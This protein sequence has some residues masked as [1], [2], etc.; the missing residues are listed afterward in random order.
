MAS[1]FAHSALLLCLLAGGCVSPVDIPTDRE[2]TPPPGSV[3]LV[4]LD[5][6]EL[7]SETCDERG[8]TLLWKRYMLQ[9]EDAILDTGQGEE[10]L[11]LLL[12]V[13]SA[14]PR[15]PR[16][17]WLDTLEI[18]ID[19]L[20]SGTQVENAAL[21][22]LRLVFWEQGEQAILR[23]V[24]SWRRGQPFPSNVRSQLALV[25]RPPGSMP[26]WLLSIRF[27]FASEKRFLRL[28]LAVLLSP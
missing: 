3:R 8:D 14:E 26:R 7:E 20:R 17:L 28:R 24:W 11:R 1:R 12:R 5:T 2:V 27:S 6:Q 18:A 23:R 22:S 9:L 21:R 25:R 13:F 16:P 15:P 19:G 4:L 10:R